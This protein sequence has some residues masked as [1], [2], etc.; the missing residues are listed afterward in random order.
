M[1]NIGFNNSVDFDLEKMCRHAIDRS[2]GLLEDISI[3]YFGSDD[4]LKYI[5]DSKCKLRRLR[6]V[7]C[8][9]NISDEGLLEIAERL[10]MLEELDITLCRNVSSVALEAIGRGC[11]LL[12]S[13]KYNDNDC[14]Y[15]RG[16]NEEAA[17]VIIAQNMPN[18]RHLQLV[19]NY[20][21][22][23]GISAILDGCPHLE[24]LDLRRGGTVELEGELRRRCDEQ[25][26]DFI[27][28]DTRY[29]CGGYEFG[30]F[31]DSEY[32]DLAYHYR[33]KKKSWWFFHNETTEGDGELSD[34][35]AGVRFEKEE[36]EGA[37]PANWEETYGIWECAKNQRSPKAFKRYLTEKE[38]KERRRR[39]MTNRK[40][41]RNT[42]EWKGN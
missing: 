25:L 42:E 40:K 41:R 4:L 12:K 23:S 17:F 31:Y 11:P 30:G 39:R 26:K 16:G 9:Y 22:N 21:N 6:L 1:C 27:E 15:Y 38:K 29:G 18:L 5:T 13:L 24:S 14:Y 8:F 28:P 34:N 7:L 32:D 33:S 3:E 35:S 10:P 37:A 2:C 19:N 20:L 36:E